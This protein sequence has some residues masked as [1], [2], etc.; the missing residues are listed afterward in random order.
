[1]IKMNPFE[2]QTPDVQPHIMMLRNVVASRYLTGVDNQKAFG[3]EWE[4]LV[5][6]LRKLMSDPII[7]AEFDF[8]DDILFSNLS[9]NVRSEQAQKLY[10]AITDLEPK[11]PYT[12]LKEEENPKFIIPNKPMY[13]IFEIDDLDEIRGFTGFYIVQEKYDGLRVQVHNFDNKVKVYSFNGNDITPKFTQLAEYLEKKDVGDFIIDGEAVL[14][15]DDD[16]LVRSDTL[17]YINKKNAESADIRIHVFDIMHFAGDEV[18]KEK[19]E[20]R[21]EVLMQNFSALANDDI[22]FP[23]KKNTRDADSKEEIARYAEEIMNNPTAEGVVIKDAKSSYIIG[24]K[25]N[26]KWV[27]WKNFVDLDVIIL[28]ARKNANNT[29]SYTMGVGPEEEGSKLK[30]IGGKKYMPVGKAANYSKKLPVGSI[31]RVKVD[32][33]LGSKEKGFTL[34]GAKIH[35]IPEV[36]QPDRAISLELLSEGGRK[37]LG[38]YKVEALKKSYTVSDGIHGI[39]KME[40]GIEP[41]GFVFYDFEKDNLM[42][43][44]ANLEMDLWKQKLQETYGKDNGRFM[45]FVAQILEDKRMSA[46]DIYNAGMDH[47]EDLMDRL[48]KGNMKKMT[49][50]LD[51]GGE[52][53]GIEKEGNRYVFKGLLKAER[54]GS[55]VLSLTNTGNLNFTF[56]YDGKKQTWEI[57]ASSD[58]ELYDFLGEAGKYPAKAVKESSQDKVIDKGTVILGAQR[59]DYH[60]YILSGKDIRSKLHVRLLPVGGKEMWLAWTGYEQKPAPKDSDKGVIDIY[61]S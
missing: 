16:P 22:T 51:N 58:E 20:D 8:E 30:S 5:L 18:Y 31:I 55:F 52:A 17:A 43:K 4:K 45:A 3:Q 21:L 44:M 53:Y 46:E 41:E 13:R 61:E 38:D 23:N 24:K 27:K 33:I 15:K 10:S 25:K 37:S 54:R 14:Y 11:K 9:L 42:A 7:R 60:E 6:E 59:T 2:V 56:I 40:Y 39:A 1:M 57:E 34:G 35:E 49:E 48:F 28:E 47:D 32:D 29:Y 26:P 36:E 50:R 12:F 19:L